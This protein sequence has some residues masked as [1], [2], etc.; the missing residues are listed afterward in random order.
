MIRLKAKF[1]RGAA[2]HLVETP[3]SEDQ[4][5]EKLDVQHV[6]VTATVRDTAQL[7]WWL[8]GFGSLAQVLEPQILAVRIA[9]ATRTGLTANQKTPEP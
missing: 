3:L 4:I 7:E 5:I 9:E 6:L 2:D 8:L 1:L